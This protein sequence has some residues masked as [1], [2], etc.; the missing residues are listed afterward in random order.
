MSIEARS[1]VLTFLI[2]DVR[3]YTSYTQAHGDEAA[4]RLAAA[5]AEIAREGVEAHGGEVIEL[6][7]DEALAV[8]ASG[9]DALRAAVDLQLVFA[10]E[11]VLHP[12]LPLRVGIGVD[13]GPAVPVEGGYRGGALNLAARLC[14]KAGPGE[15]FVSEGAL[16][17]TGPLD[18]LDV[19]PHGEFEM[20]GLAEPV[21]VSRVSFADVDPDLL[22]A[23]FDLDGHVEPRPSEVPTELDTTTPIVGRDREIHRL[24]WAWRRARRG[25]GSALLVLG[26]PGI[27]KTR[28]IAELAASV[29]HDGAP[30]TYLNGRD[31]SGELDVDPD[32]QALYVVDDVG[33]GDGGFDAAK[34][35][36]GHT[37]GTRSLAIVA[38]DDAAPTDEHRAFVRGAGDAVVRPAPL[39]L[40]GIR[41]IA[42][43]YL[44]ASAEA[45]PAS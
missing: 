18:G 27:G 39:D 42:G 40:D 6:R 23:R 25:E 13:T 11:V 43:L 7:G 9:A 22:A 30:V 15:V 1:R 33:E 38:M 32:A 41:E 3:G 17:L 19:H 10:D 37:P 14:S 36:W 24:R 8:F 20:K 44:G 26:P 45:L 28:L 21:S 2:A 35:L 34:A 31:P 4:A 12:G 16:D 29:A 5:F